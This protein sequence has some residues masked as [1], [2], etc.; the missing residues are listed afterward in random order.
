M[1][2]QESLILRANDRAQRRLRAMVETKTYG[3]PQAIEPKLYT[4]AERL[5]DSLLTELTWE[6]RKAEVDALQE[7][8][9]DYHLLSAEPRWD[10]DD[11]VEDNQAF[12]H[13]NM[14]SY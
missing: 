6:T 4:Q 5:V 12:W 14:A 1:M 3:D 10:C 8:D 2:Q 9:H 7:A 11:C 13:R